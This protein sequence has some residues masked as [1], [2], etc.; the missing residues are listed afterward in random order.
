MVTRLV[1]ASLVG[2]GHETILWKGKPIDHVV[3]SGIQ[4]WKHHTHHSCCMWSVFNYW[5]IAHIK[6]CPSS[7][8]IPPLVLN[9]ELKTPQLLWSIFNYWIVAHIKRCPSSGD[10]P[11]LEFYNVLHVHHNKLVPTSSTMGL[12]VHHNIFTY[13]LTSPPIMG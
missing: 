11:P 5:I 4:T 12:H 2:S 6:R 3:G 7:R 8:D 10:I 13:L 1:S 9:M